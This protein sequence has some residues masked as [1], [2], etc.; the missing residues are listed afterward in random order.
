VRRGGFNAYI[1]TEGVREIEGW[2][3]VRGTTHF[4]KGRGSQKIYLPE[5]SQAVPA[6][7]SGRCRLVAR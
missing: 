1:L 3:A 6:R 7:P 4:Q 2:V 5:G